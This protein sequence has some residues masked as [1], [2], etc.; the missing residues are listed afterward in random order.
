M[1]QQNVTDCTYY[2]FNSAVCNEEIW[3]ALSKACNNGNMTLL[4][5]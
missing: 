1:L 2:S 3:N 5:E 4:K